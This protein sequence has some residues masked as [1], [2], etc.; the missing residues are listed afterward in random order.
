MLFLRVLLLILAGASARATTVEPPTFP[1]LVDEADAIYRGRV[2]GVQ[3]RRVAGPGGSSLIKTFVTF[4]IDRTLKGAS[5]SETVL[6]F[7]GGAVGED[8]MEVGGMPQFNVGERS[9]VFIQKNGVQ[10]CPLVRVMHGRYRV[11]RDESTGQE[12]VARDNHA[13]LTDVTEVAQPL[14]DQ[15]ALTT[16]TPGRAALARA[17]SP[18]DF[19]TRI[20]G[21]VLHPTPRETAPR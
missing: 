11:A 8:T 1:Q 21:E 10:L 6:E 17:L 7:L 12:Y 14:G 16:A 9:I 20:T 5:Q 19:E 18:A 2:T 3:A 15:P 4:K 13:P